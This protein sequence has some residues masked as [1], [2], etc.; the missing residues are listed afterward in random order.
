MIDTTLGHVRVMADNTEPRDDHAWRERGYAADG[1]RLGDGMISRLGGGGCGG[2]M[3]D[4]SDEGQE[5]V[6]HCA[7]LLIA[8]E[9]VSRHIRL[10]NNNRDLLVLLLLH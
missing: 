9:T 7:V 8:I 2:R 6:V 3:K 10:D 1:H 5:T 4:Q